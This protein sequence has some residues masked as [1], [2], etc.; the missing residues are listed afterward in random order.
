[1]LHACL[2]LLARGVRS[3]KQLLLKQRDIM[4][5]LTN[6]ITERDGTIASLEVRPAP[7]LPPSKPTYRALEYPGVP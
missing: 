2:F 4:I 1:M 5:A 6:R 7:C 3:Y